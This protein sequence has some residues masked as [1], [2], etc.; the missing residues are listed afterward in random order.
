MS[1]PSKN[2]ILV[3]D[4]DPGVLNSF[5][6]LLQ[7]SG[8]DV[9]SATNGFDALLQLKRKLPSILISDLNMP[10]MSGFELLSVVR[11]RFPKISVIAMSGAYHSG[12]AVPGGV[13][14]DAFYSKG[15]SN[16]GAFLGMVAE[17]IQT[18]A[19]HA[20]EHERQSAPVWIPR[21][22]K[23]PSGIPYVVLTCTECLRSFPLSV[24][25]DHIQKI[26]ETPCLFCPNTVR[27]I[28]DFSL[29]AALPRP[30]QPAVEGAAIDRG[31]SNAV[32]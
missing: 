2:E 26:Q 32:A 3:V 1:N 11:R 27:Y 18:S 19:A 29:S 30:P 25:T 9:S 12:D 5:V 7:S 24:A 4:D 14:A 10:Q 13:I 28:I 17:L 22:G 23:D 15:H 8:Y 21:N 16:P 6:L 20:V 31:S